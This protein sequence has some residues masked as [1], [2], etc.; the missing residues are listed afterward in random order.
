MYKFLLLLSTFTLLMKVCAETTSNQTEISSP[1]NSSRLPVQR[2]LHFV[3]VGQNLKIFDFYSL[4]ARK[5]DN[6]LTD[7]HK[8]DDPEAW[9]VQRRKRLLA[10]LVF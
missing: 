4:K 3:V 8:I 2:P 1:T 9:F 5:G 6:P 7:A 10:M